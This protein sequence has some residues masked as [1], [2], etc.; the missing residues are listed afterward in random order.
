MAASGSTRSRRGV[1]I[2]LDRADAHWCCTMR[3]ASAARG[4]R[5]VGRWWQ[6]LTSRSV[7]ARQLRRSR[8]MAGASGTAADGHR[9]DS[10]FS[11]PRTPGP[12]IE[13]SGGRARLCELGQR[14]QERVS[15][16]F[17]QRPSRWRAGTIGLGRST[18]RSSVSTSRT[19]VAALSEIAGASMRMSS[20]SALRSLLTGA[21]RHR[22]RSTSDGTAARMPPFEENNENSHRVAAH[23]VGARLAGLP[24]RRRRS[25]RPPFPSRRR[26]WCPWYSKLPACLPARRFGGSSANPP[27]T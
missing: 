4:A 7:P 8:Q 24:P 18:C 3:G 26:V 14:G 15:V 17:L 2:S 5:D 16:R 19:A 13:V 11:R 6:A 22:L 25:A 20:S 1:A 21:E 27:A 23:S 10:R 9:A 12:R